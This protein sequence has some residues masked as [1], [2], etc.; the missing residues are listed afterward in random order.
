M[1]ADVHERGAASPHAVVVSAAAQ[2]LLAPIVDVFNRAF[3][4]IVKSAE[5]WAAAVTGAMKPAM[6]A[7]TAREDR[8]L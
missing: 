6:Q 7:L 2:E 3:G 8:P 5:A 1:V 4:D